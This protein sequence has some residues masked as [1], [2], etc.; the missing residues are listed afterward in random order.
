MRGKTG[1][2]SIGRYVAHLQGD[3]I[4]PSLVSGHALPEPTVTGMAY[5]SPKRYPAGAASKKVF[6]AP[7]LF[8]P[9]ALE[10]R[11]YT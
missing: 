9:S 4:W 5:R 11:L 2:A 7:P 3:R 6:D 8:G 10:G 1:N